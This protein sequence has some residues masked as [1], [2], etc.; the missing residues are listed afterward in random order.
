MIDIALVDDHKLLRSG[1]AALVQ[2]FGN[3]NILF[4]ANNGKECLDLLNLGKIPDIILLDINMPIM[5]GFETSKQLHTNY[6]NIK[7]LI[8]TMLDNDY[9]VVKMLRNGVKGYLLKDSK[10]EAFKEAINE[11]YDNGFYINQLVTSKLKLL[12]NPQLHGFEEDLSEKELAFLKLCC[13]E[14]SYKEIAID[15]NITPRAAEAIRS[16][17]FIKLDTSSRIGL[18]MYAIKNGIVNIT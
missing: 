9:A 11:V 5:D 6:P 1:L 18:A 12:L 16:N 4:E 3:C 15:M 8:L 13:T 14:K 7:V 10:P 2:S 17:L